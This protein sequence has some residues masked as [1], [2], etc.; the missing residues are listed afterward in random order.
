M[1]ERGESL[2]ALRGRR[3]VVTRS[4]AQAGELCARLEE[5]G[6]E[7][8]LFPVIRVVTLETPELER[9]VERIGGFDW[10]VLTSVNAVECLCARLADRHP[11]A[12]AAL[13]PIAAVGGATARA[14]ASRGLAPA[15]V[16]SEFRAEALVEGL[17]D[18]EGR[19][20]LLPRS[21]I[22]RPEIVEGLR[23]RGARV[24]DLPLYDVVRAVPTPE[25]RRELEAGFDVITFTSPS[26]VRNLLGIL[27]DTGSGR[28]LLR[29]AT[30]ACI[31]PVTADE[32]RAQGLPV[33]VVPARF[34][35][36]DLAAALAEHLAGSGRPP[37]A[38]YA[39]GAEGGS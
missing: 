12:Y 18:L 7:A 13:P 31:G 25:A 39:A 16:P 8:I 23:R 33:H 17:G 14:L 34:T 22:G 20:V 3:I 26:S 15:F 19:N 10:L 5:V 29:G 37:V 35:V 9:L 1:G 30:V 21:R 11:E 4:A 2:A 24:V 32:A 36:P 38:S 6:A 27:D 28:E